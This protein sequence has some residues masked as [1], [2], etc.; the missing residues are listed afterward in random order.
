MPPLTIP[1]A[2]RDV[3]GMMRGSILCPSDEVTVDKTR[4]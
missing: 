3:A 4:Y 2:A 1:S